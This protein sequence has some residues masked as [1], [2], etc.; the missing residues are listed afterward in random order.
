LH[1]QDSGQLAGGLDVVRTRGDA[2]LQVREAGVSGSDQI[3]VAGELS[4]RLITDDLALNLACLIDEEDSGVTVNVVF[5]GDAL[6]VFFSV[7]LD[8]NKLFRGLDN[9]LVGIGLCIQA[10]TPASPV[11]VEVDHDQLV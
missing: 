11:C 9:D 2:L 8:R 4:S 6:A 10:L 1:G 5:G 3:E 7:Q